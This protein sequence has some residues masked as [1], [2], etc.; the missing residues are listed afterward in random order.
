M[1]LA[2]ELELPD[3]AVDQSSEAELVRSIKEQTAL[4]LYSQQRLTTGEAAEMLG[5]TRIEYLDYLRR[6]GIGF[7]VEMVNGFRFQRPH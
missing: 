7:Q 4:K 5:L 3:G 6:S 1:K 2:F